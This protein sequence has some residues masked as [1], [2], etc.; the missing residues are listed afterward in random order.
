MNSAQ[1]LEPTQESGAA[2]FAREITGQVV[3]LNLLRFRDVADYSASPELAP[4]EPV[5]GHDA[6][7]AYMDHTLPFLIASGGE[8]LFLGEGGNY[9]IGPQ[10]EQWDM[11][12]LVRHKSLEGFMAFAKNEGYLAGM[13]HRTAALEDSR[14]LPIVALGADGVANSVR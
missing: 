3:M 2:L 14:L 10:E 13:G 11:V 7:Q 12:L 1:F 6:Y 4:P 5:S 9:L 8:V